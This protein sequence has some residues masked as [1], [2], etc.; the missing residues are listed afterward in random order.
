MA[1][2]WAKKLCAGNGQFYSAGVQKKIVDPC[3]IQVM[4]EA[5]VDITSQYSKTTT[6]LPEVKMD[7]V[8]TLCSQALTA[9]P[10]FPGN[11]NIHR[12]FDDPPQLTAKMDDEEAI[13]R[14]YRRV[15]DEIKDFV[16][17]MADYGNE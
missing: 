7:I 13:L 4:A 8:F 16:Q 14:V 6:E 3:A 1:E 11:K 2:G 9:C 10:F 5:G 17:N 12:G 15:R